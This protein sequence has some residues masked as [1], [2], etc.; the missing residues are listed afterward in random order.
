MSAERSEMGCADCDSLN[1]N[2]ESLFSPED[3][4]GDNG[5]LANVS[6]SGSF[7]WVSCCKSGASG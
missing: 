5:L 4:G 1:W 7:D 2:W 6:S 3:S